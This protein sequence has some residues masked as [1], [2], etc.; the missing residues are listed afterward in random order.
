MPCPNGG[1]RC[2]GVGGTA[3][4]EATRR[5]ALDDGRR[6]QWVDARDGRRGAS[7]RREPARHGGPRY[8]MYVG[9]RHAVPLRGLRCCG[10]GGTAWGG[11]AC[12]GDP[13]G[14]PYNGRR[15]ASPRREPAR[16]VGPR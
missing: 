10:V 6:T 1:L 7:P 4:R 16:H 5:V 3:W 12:R 15:G 11:T 2:C 8:G 13:A 14:R 9:A